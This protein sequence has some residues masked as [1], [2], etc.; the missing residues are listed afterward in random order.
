M[1][2]G[3]ILTTNNDSTSKGTQGDIEKLKEC[4]DVHYYKECGWFCVAGWKKDS[5]GNPKRVVHAHF[6]SQEEFEYMKDP[7][8][9]WKQMYDEGPSSSPFR[10]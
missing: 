3:T 8:A 4:D 2:F 10:R 9:A 7:S 6:N 5:F 1:V